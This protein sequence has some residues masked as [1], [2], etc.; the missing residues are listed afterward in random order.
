MNFTH[1]DHGHILPELECITTPKM[2]TYTTPEGNKYPSATTVL[3][4]DDSKKAGLDAWV[5]RV[6]REEADRVMRIAAT[7]GEAVHTLAENFL[8]NDPD[9]KKG[10]MPINVATF[11]QI[12]PWLVEHV[13]NV[14]AQE[15][16]LYSDRLQAAGRVDCIAEW[17]GQLSIIDFKTSLRAKKKEWITSYFMQTAFYAAAF[18]ERT[19]VAVKNGV[20]V[21]AVDNDLPQYFEVNTFDYLKG[22]IELR[23][24]FRTL[25]NI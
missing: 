5:E 22:F 10:A 2:R 6:G 9:W 1:V 11:G 13:D 14:W 23:H 24:L 16:P 15:V 8:N 17:K 21:I 7:R 3:S 20:V 19:G 18:Y 4:V 25:K 12:K